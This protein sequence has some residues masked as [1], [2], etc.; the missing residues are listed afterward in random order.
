[1]ICPLCESEYRDGVTRCSDCDVDLVDELAPNAYEEALTALA[2]NIT[3]DVL[4]ELT[5]R[6]EKTGV[7]Y[8]VEAGTALRLLDHPEEPMTKP[9]NWEARVW[10]ASP[11]AE[12]AK[13]IYSEI[14]D[15]LRTGD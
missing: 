1:M 9:D 2:S 6:L 15:R 13:R 14:Q 4:A 12:R 11:F 5:D 3:S 10:I 7:P 8:V